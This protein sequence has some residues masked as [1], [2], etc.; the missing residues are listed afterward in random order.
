MTEFVDLAPT[1]G[2]QA[3]LPTTALNRADRRRLLG[4]Q[5]CTRAPRVAH[6][7]TYTTGAALPPPPASLDLT[8]GAKE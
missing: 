7:S 4:R 5:E 3:A 6:Y 8:K 1:L 2:R